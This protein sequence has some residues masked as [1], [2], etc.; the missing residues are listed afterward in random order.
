M[1]IKYKHIIIVT[2]LAILFY[3]FGALFKIL[4][5]AFPFGEGNYFGGPELIIIS[6]ILW[7]IA[8]GLLI[9]KALNAKG[10]DFLNR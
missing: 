3:L 5:W 6:V 9:F 8:G 4:H 2:V 1:K 10:Y 7:V